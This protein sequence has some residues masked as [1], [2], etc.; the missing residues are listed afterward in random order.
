MKSLLSWRAVKA[1]LGEDAIPKLVFLAGLAGAFYLAGM[2]A[3][4]LCLFPTEVVQD[5]HAAWRALDEVQDSS[6][7]FGAQKSLASRDRPLV[8]RLDARAGSENILFAGG[9][10]QYM[11]ECPQ[12]G[13]VAI[14]ADRSGAILHSWQ[15]DPA[16][17]FD[18]EAIEGF[19]G[20]PGKDIDEFYVNA[21]A[22]AADGG[23][24]VT[25]Q[26]INVFPYQVGIAKLDAKGK[27]LWKRIDHSHHWATIDGNGEILVPYSNFVDGIKR[28]GDTATDIRCEDGVVSIEGV[29]R[30][31]PDGSLLGELSF[32]DILLRADYPG[33]VYAVR[34]GC[35]PYHVNAITPV[36]PAAAQALASAGVVAG[37]LLVSL[38][39]PS[40]L[41][42]IGR[43]TGELKRLIVGRTS[44]QHSPRFL[45][46][47]SIVVFDNRGGKKETGG[48]R[49][50][51][52]DLATR[53][54]RVVY[55]RSDKDPLL[56]FFSPL[57]GV[58]DVS[59]DG[60]RLLVSDP[61]SARVIEIDVATG[62]SLW[63]YNKTLDMTPYLERRHLSTRTPFVRFATH[64]AYYVSDMSVLK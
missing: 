52:I 29:R 13:C 57:G 45:P 56:P 59:A 62:A 5:A 42:I 51:R 22:L 4:E 8:Q 63:V 53:Q 16:E 47:G 32:A 1:V 37:D 41:A 19:D 61:R 20:A 58:I 11:D 18:E 2:V 36:P 38:R 17:L 9:F 54:T 7:P 50:L 40:A 44:G 21:V 15:I 12:F 55:P 23:L 10:Y 46:D 34:D 30:L 39:E 6:L 3:R 35:D 49:I 31:G 60:S 28:F 64:G 24:V 48:S 25:L 26:A 43:T 33:I 14:V 27:L